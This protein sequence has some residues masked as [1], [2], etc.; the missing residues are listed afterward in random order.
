MASAVAI[1]SS[2][3]FWRSLAIERIANSSFW[4]FGSGSSDPKLCS[5]DRQSRRESAIADKRTMAAAEFTAT[6]ERNDSKACSE[7]EESNVGTRGVLGRWWSDG[8]LGTDRE[9]DG[10]HYPCVI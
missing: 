6:L 2:S 4:G 5:H 8:F 1:A 10:P 3:M 7:N 9:M